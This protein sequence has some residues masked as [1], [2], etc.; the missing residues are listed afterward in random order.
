MTTYQGGCHC[1]AVRYQVEADLSQVISC[2][3]SHCGIKGMMLSFTP[4]ANFKLLQGQEQLTTYLFNKQLIQHQFCKICGVQSFAQGTAP[5]G[6]QM[7]AIN[8]RC[9][10][11]VDWE[12]LKIRH[13]NGKEI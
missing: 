11:G 12:Q 2:N 6:S 5:D 3:C 7:H 9:L 1:Q 8:A 4:S 10:D 13:I